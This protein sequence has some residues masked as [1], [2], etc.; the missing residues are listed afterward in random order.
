MAWKEPATGEEKWQVM[1]TK[2]LGD[3]A[4]SLSWDNLD[5]TCWFLNNPLSHSG[6][7]T[8]LISREMLRTFV[9]AVTPVKKQEADMHRLFPSEDVRGRGDRLLFS[10]VIHEKSQFTGIEPKKRQII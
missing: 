2:A 9:G 4:K 10:N 3:S 8:L 5:R 1:V 6:D 7:S